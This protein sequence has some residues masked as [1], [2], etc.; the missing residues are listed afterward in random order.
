MCQS[1]Q[2]ISVSE[3]FYM[4]GYL[5]FSQLYEPKP[6]TDLSKNLRIVHEHMKEAC[7]HSGILGKPTVLLVH[8]DLGTDCLQ[9]VAAL[10][11]QGRNR[12][13]ITC[14]LYFI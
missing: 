11:A 3:G 4:V 9:D 12:R 14:N 13:G 10:M 1:E 2:N 5:F 7:K 6:Q 8:E